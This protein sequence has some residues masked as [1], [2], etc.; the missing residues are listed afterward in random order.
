M[1]CFRPVD[2]SKIRRGR[3]CRHRVV[4]SVSRL[5]PSAAI[6]IAKHWNGSAETLEGGA[7]SSVASG[8]IDGLIQ[9]HPQLFG[10]TYGMSSAPQ[11]P[12]DGFR[13][14]AMDPDEGMRP[15]G[16]AKDGD[17]H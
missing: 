3:Q 8:F 17:I 16:F 13:F 10:A 5:A 9:R 14:S 12:D 6:L 11:F 4:P 2:S 7:V 1:N 15:P